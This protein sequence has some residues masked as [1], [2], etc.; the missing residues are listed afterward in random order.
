MRF[1]EAPLTC[2][3]KSFVM[4]KVCYNA[5]PM[6]AFT[7]LQKR[8]FPVYFRGQTLLLL[9]TALTH[10]PY[11]PV[12]LVASL[13][14]LSPL[15]FGGAMAAWNFMVWGPRAQTAMIERIHQGRLFLCPRSLLVADAV[16]SQRPKTERNT[17]ILK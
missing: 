4:T 17:M 16:G 5:L 2:D 14:D 10:P 11:G 12:S 13:W 7:T 1:V 8:V 3:T 9:L 6:S 15:A